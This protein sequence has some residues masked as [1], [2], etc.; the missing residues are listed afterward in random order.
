MKRVKS[1][2]SEILKLNSIIGN[3]IAATSL[4][5]ICIDEYNKTQANYFS[6]AANS[7]SKF[8]AICNRIEKSNLDNNDKQNCLRLIRA[9]TINSLDNS[10]MLSSH[11]KIKSYV[12]NIIAARY[13][14]SLRKL[15]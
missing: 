8:F 13:K 1:I 7:I 11:L 3:S 6:P 10:K 12:E 2:D 5:R 9:D 15:K 4:K 14:K